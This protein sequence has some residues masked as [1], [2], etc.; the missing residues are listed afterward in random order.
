MER[1]YQTKGT[2]LLRTRFGTVN[3]DN[4]TISPEEMTTN[5]GWRQKAGVKDGPFCLVP[6]GLDIPF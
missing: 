1:D 6:N 3:A 4:F 5:E 2:I